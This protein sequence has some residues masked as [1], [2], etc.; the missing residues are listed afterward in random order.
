MMIV[1][2]PRRVLARSRPGGLPP[3]RRIPFPALALAVCL[4][5][6]AV[7]VAVLDDYGIARDEFAQRRL[8]EKNAAYIMGDRDALP[9]NHDRF[10]GIAFELPLLLAERLLGLKDIRD[11]YLSR[12]LITHLFFI[13]GGFCCGLLAWRMSHNR[14]LALLV[15]LLFLLHPRLYAHSFFNSKDIPFLVM[16][17]IALYLTHRAF[18]Q[19][20]AGG[21]ALLGIVVGL[22]VNVR[23]FALLLAAAVLTMRGLDLWQASDSVRRRRILLTG[24]VFAAAALLALYTSQPYY[25]ENPLRYFDSFYELSQ[26][27]IE[28]RNLFRGQWIL[29]YELPAEYIPVWFGITA[30]PVALLL[31]SAGIATA[32]WRGWRT[33]GGYFTTANC[34]SCF[35]CWPVLRCLSPPP[36]YCNPRSTTTGGICTSSGGLFVCWRLAC[37]SP[38]G[39]RRETCCG[40]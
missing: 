17:V 40:E 31:G 18:R 6:A 19:D 16:F 25:W 8:A 38:Q 3:L 20:T 12:H 36:S 26:R 23:P 10:Y 24:G 28:I 32:L 33:P 5:F 39:K 11:I 4:L 2:A 15:M 35:C 13:V 30:P 22:A 9:T 21:F 29:S 34:V 7:G 14:W 27:P 1:L 37:T